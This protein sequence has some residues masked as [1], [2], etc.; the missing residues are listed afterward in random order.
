MKPRLGRTFGTIAVLGL[1][2]TASASA[3]ITRVDIAVVESPAFNG[4]HFGQVGP[5]EQLRGIVYGEV[6]PADP[7][8]QAIV[9]LEHAPRN[10]S[11][12]VEYTATVEIYR[13]VDMNR[14]NR[15]IHH[16]VPNRG[17]LGE[18]EPTL[19]ELGLALVWVGWQG[20]IDPTDRNIVASLPVAT[21]S[22]NSA[23][24]GPAL[25]EFIFDDSAS[26][27]RGTLTYPSASNN[28]V[29]AMLTVRRTQ[30]AERLTPPHLKWKYLNLSQIEITRP[31]GF[32]GGAIYEFVYQAKD[33]IV[34][35]LGFAPIRDTISFLRYEHTDREGNPNP[36]A[37]NGLP[38]TAISL[39]ISQSGRVLRDFLYQGFNE[40]VEGRIVFDGIHPN[41]AGSRKTFTNY[42]FGQPGRWQKQHEDHVYPGDQF[43]FTYASLTDTISGRSDGLLKRCTATNTCPKIIHSDGEAELWQGRASLVVTD[44]NGRHIELPDNVRVYLMA[45]TQHGGG[46]GVHAETPARGLC[47]NFG[48]PLPLRDIRLALNVALHEWVAEAVEPPPSRFPTVANGGLVSP[49]NSQFPDIP[50]VSYSGSYNPLR[51][52]D[53]TTIPPEPGDAYEVLLPAMDTDGNM[54]AGIRHPNLAAPIGTYTGWNLRSTGFAEGAQCGGMGSFIPFA[55]SA[56]DRKASSDPR[57]SLAE[58][59]PNHQ[60]YVDAVSTAATQLVEERFLLPV[61]AKRIVERARASGIAEPNR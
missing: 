32:D 27:S 58:R 24:E 21:R 3:Q 6:D 43:P 5:Y 49:A 44:S 26:V 34:M 39:G 47:Q 41:I 53:H 50:G 35:G 48:N 51:L 37:F 9:N 22:D 2:V 30:T 8:H 18:V 38:R 31:T 20:D 56:A 29:Q 54:T 52:H 59:Y 13:P 19:L 16:T 1:I 36:L 25:E 42:A 33:P 15:A 40:D 10:E 14:W 45:G 17:R 4:R 7:R 11:G 61:D 23:I 28:P 55:L 57:R 46:G 60:V 12:R